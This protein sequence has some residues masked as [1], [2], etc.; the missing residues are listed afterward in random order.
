MQY[1]IYNINILIYKLYI[2]SFLVAIY[3]SNLYLLRTPVYTKILK[4][5]KSLQLRFYSHT[6]TIIGTSA[7]RRTLRHSVHRVLFG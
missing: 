7:T 2:A 5:I 1:E 3:K 6:E 4:S